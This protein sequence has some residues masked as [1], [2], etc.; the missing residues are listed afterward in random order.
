MDTLTRGPLL[1]VNKAKDNHGFQYTVTLTEC[2]IQ[3]K[4]CAGEDYPRKHDFTLRIENTPGQW[5]MTTLEEKPNRGPV[6]SIDMGQRWDCINFDVIMTEAKG[7]LKDLD[8]L[9]VVDVEAADA[10][11]WANFQRKVGPSF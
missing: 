9:T 11:T 5:Y 4:G 10:I 8:R 3:F 6:I 2:E 7:L 1:L